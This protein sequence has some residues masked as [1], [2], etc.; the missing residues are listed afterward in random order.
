MSC[1]EIGE[2]IWLSQKERK[3]KMKM[4]KMAALSA[5]LTLAMAT[6]NADQTNVV[7][8]LRVQLRGVQPGGPVATRVTVT[9]G[10]AAARL[11]TRQIIQ[12]LGAATGNTF[13]YSARLVVVTPLGGGDSSIQIRDGAATADV[14]AF[15]IHQQLSASV[16]GAVSNIVTHRTTQLDYSI[17]RFA[18]Q[19]AEGFPPLNLHFDVSGFAEERSAANL[20]GVS[21]SQVDVSGSGDAS[22]SL[23]ILQGS[24][25]VDGSRLEVVAGGGGGVN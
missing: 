10:F 15:F 18:L 9:T 2:L 11:D 20:P 23:M 13:S 19:D 12:A 21:Y 14:T 1:T 16:S 5:L 3:H 6:A 4:L 17:Q 25:E 24:V 22:G 8:N 7:Q